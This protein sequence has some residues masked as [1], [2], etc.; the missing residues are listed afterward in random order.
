MEILYSQLSSLNKDLANDDG[1][2]SWFNLAKAP[3]SIPSTP[4]QSEIPSTPSTGPFNIFNPL[5]YV[6]GVVPNIFK[7]RFQGQCSLF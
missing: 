7:D 3:S 6:Q 5:S 4:Q 1:A 2:L